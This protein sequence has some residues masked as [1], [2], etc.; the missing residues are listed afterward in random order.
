MWGKPLDSA[1]MDARLP[2]AVHR[3]AHRVISDQERAGLDILTPATTSSTPDFAGRSWHHYPLQRWIGPR[4]RRAA[5]HDDHV[6]LAPTRPARCCTRSTRVALAASSWARSSRTPTT[7]SSTP[8]SAACPGA[9]AQAGQVRHGLRAGH[10]AVP[11]L[12]T[13]VTT[14]GQQAPDRLGHGDGHQP[15]SCASS[16]PRAA[17]CPARGAD[18]PL[19]GGASIP[20]EGLLDFLVEAVNHELSGPRRT[21]RSGCTP[22]GATR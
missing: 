3:R 18:D 20:T 17:R 22:A 14:R 15:A 8:R 5:D 16:W 12:H 4:V 11:R 21:P 19:H 9:H 6:G 7:R 13:D 2:R 10:G 1:M